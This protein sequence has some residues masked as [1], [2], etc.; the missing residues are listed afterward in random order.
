MREREKE[1]KEE[2]KERARMRARELLS[3]WMNERAIDC[4]CV[5]SECMYVC[6]GACVHTCV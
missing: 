2:E 5:D 6:T 3:E 4:V 1:E